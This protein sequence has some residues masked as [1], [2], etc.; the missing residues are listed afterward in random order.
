MGLW[1]SCQWRPVMGSVRRASTGRCP[2]ASPDMSRHVPTQNH[3]ALTSHWS[4]QSPP[5]QVLQSRYV[6]MSFPSFY[7]RFFFPFLFI[8]VDF[9]P[10]IFNSL[11]DV[12]IVCP[13]NIIVVFFNNSEKKKKKKMRNLIETAFFFVD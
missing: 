11:Q 2:R 13:C 9:I 10:C 6:I 8:I 5:D 12:S 4:L 7:R 3:G 1:C